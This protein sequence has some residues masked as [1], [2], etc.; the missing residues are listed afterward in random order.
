MYRILKQ[1]NQRRLD[2]P[3][4]F[5]MNFRES[6]KKLLDEALTLNPELFLISLKIGA[7]SAVH[8]TLD[9][10]HGVTLKDC[11]N[12]SRHIEH[13]LD[14]D[15]HDFS[16]EVASAGVGTPLV[17]MRQYTKNINRKLEVT[18]SEGPPVI[19]T[20]VAVDQE[21]FTLEWKQREP[22]PIGK[23]KVTVT[24][25]KQLSYDSIVNAKVVL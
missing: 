10:D 7:D 1:L 23:G 2:S 18:L 9:G 3:F 15:E 14:R 19:G 5:Y 12:I 20:L 11:M 8:I 22:K 16:L 25:N 24:K 6:V 21:T 13:A 17:N 4:F